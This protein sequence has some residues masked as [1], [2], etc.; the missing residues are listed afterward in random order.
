MVGSGRNV[1]PGMHND[2]VLGIQFNVACR[3][4][5]DEFSVSGKGE[6]VVLL[7]IIV[8]ANISI[9]AFVVYF[10]GM[11]VAGTD[12]LDLI[13]AVAIGHPSG[14]GVTNAII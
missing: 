12:G 3:F 6:D 1:V 13:L 9:V 5:H 14:V 10:Y 4:K 11:S 2:I 8:D 7:F